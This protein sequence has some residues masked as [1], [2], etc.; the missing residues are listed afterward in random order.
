[1]FFKVFRPTSY[2][3]NHTTLHALFKNENA[4][5]RGSFVIPLQSCN[6]VTNVY[7][8]TKVNLKLYSVFTYEDFTLVRKN[9]GKIIKN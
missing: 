6:S 7:Q 8:D 1:M 5:I 9:A 4:L 3:L 2:I